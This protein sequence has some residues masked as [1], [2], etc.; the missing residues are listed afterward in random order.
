MMVNK[1]EQYQK[2]VEKRQACRCCSDFGLK[3][4]E[5][6]LKAKQK[7]DINEIGQWTASYTPTSKGSLNAKIVILGQDWGTIEEYN[8]FINSGE[9]GKFPT[10]EYEFNTSP[11]NKN[12]EIGL[13]EID[14]EVDLKKGNFGECFMTNAILCYKTGKMSTKIKDENYRRC[15]QKFL[16]ELLDII[17]PEIIIVLGKQTFNAVVQCSK[18][19]LVDEGNVYKK[20]WYYNRTILHGLKG[21]FKY[22]LKEHEILV[23]PMAHTGAL[24][25]LNRNRHQNAR[26][27]IK[28]WEDLS[29]YLKDNSILK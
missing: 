9:I 27:F 3:N 13:K 6:I 23:F 15:I 18:G 21:N 25:V 5:E 11:T 8:N 19:N 1:K 24:G 17:K 16:Y 29:D 2:L 14:K 7:K 20:S 22:C 4:G 12:L 28:D 10:S 26:E